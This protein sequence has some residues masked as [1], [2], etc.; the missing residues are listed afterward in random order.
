MPYKKHR[1]HIMLLKGGGSSPIPI[2]PTAFQRFKRIRWTM[3][4]E[5]RKLIAKN[6]RKNL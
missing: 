5:G 2:I 1:Q 6:Y 3:G 4:N